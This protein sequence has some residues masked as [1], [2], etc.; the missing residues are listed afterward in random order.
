MIYIHF[1]LFYCLFFLSA[2]CLFAFLE[3]SYALIN[4]YFFLIRQSETQKN[5][6]KGA[7]FLPTKTSAAVPLGDLSSR[8]V[9]IV[10]LTFR[11]VVW[12]LEV[13]GIFQWTQLQG[14]TLFW[15]STG[16][17]VKMGGR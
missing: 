12:T 3:Q 1:H 17:R 11:S 9:G 4:P 14:M 2:N 16:K 8:S 10:L 13:L 7:H 15:T 5:F 6:S